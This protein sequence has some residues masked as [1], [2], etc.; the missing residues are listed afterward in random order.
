MRPRRPKLNGSWA[1]QGCTYGLIASLSILLWAVSTLDARSNDRWVL[2]IGNGD[3]QSLSNLNRSA[4][5]AEFYKELFVTAG[6]RAL[7]DK[8]HKHLNQDF[9]RGR[10]GEVFDA[11]G[12]GGGEVVITYSGHGVA[13]V[14]AEGQLQTY[15]VPVDATFRD[16]QSAS[17]IQGNLVSVQSI[18]ESAVKARISRLILIIDACRTDPIFTARAEFVRGSASIELPGNRE[19]TVIFS[20]ASGQVAYESLDSLGGELG[21]NAEHSVFTRFF[22]RNIVDTP[23]LIDAF[24]DTQIDV[25]K[26]TARQDDGAQKPVIF[27]TMTREFELKAATENAPGQTPVVDAPRWVIRPRECRTNEA[28]LREAVEARDRG[29][30][31][32]ETAWANRQCVSQ[33]ALRALGVGRLRETDDRYPV[34]VGSIAGRSA[35]QSGDAFDAVNVQSNAEERG[36]TRPIRV[37][38]VEDLET[39]L[40]EHAFKDDL[41]WTFFIRRGEGTQFLNNIFIP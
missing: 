15:L 35:F 39:F 19:Y 16:D 12:A 17:F 30:I 8:A 32:D 9:L 24:L 21:D 28:M 25:M 11:A 4:N 36:R 38:S 13:M 34:V 23:S 2:A 26:E 27:T 6:Y 18:V 37:R 20:S 3:Y 10:I 1:D 14:D 40:G 5:D 31:S 41:S 33:A 7:N 22:K 29:T